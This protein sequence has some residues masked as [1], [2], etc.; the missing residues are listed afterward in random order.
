MWMQRLV[1]CKMGVGG[2]EMFAV[3]NFSSSARSS[4][5]FEDYDEP[6]LCL[7]IQFVPYSKYTLFPL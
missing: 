1:D 2:D 4:F 5:W 3:L 6:V 7:K